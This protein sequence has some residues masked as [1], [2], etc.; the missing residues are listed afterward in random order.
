MLSPTR[1][2]NEYRR[3]RKA[4]RR[5]VSAPVGGWN[6]RDA[7]HAMPPKDA[8]TLDNWFPAVG[9]VN[10]RK[11][12]EQY[13]T[14]VGASDVESLFEYHSGST[15]KFLGAGGG[16][17]YDISSAGAG[18]SLA[19]GF[20]SN[21]WQ[22]TMFNT[23]LHLVNGS[24]DP[25]AYDGS[26]ISS[27]AWSGTGLTISTLNGVTVYRERLFFWQVASQ[28]FWY[29]GVQSVSGTLTKFPMSMLG[30]LGGNIVAMSPWAYADQGSGSSE[31]LAIVMSSGE[32]VVYAGTDPGVAAN[33]SLVGIWKIGAPI[34]ARGVLKL[35]GDLIILT[36]DDWISLKSVVMKDRADRDLSKISGAAQ[37]AALDY[38]A[39][40]GWGVTHYPKGNFLLVNVPV[41]STRFDQHVLNTT[42]KAWCRFTG[43]NGRCWATYNDALYFGGG[44]GKVFKADTGTNDNSEVISADA[45]QAWSNFGYVDPKRMTMIMPV[46]S[47]PGT[48]TITFGLGFDFKEVQ[49]EQST[50]SVASGPLW[51]IATWDTEQWA[52][53][54]APRTDWYDAAGEGVDVSLRLRYSGKGQT[55]DWFR[56]DYLFVPGAGL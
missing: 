30:R 55:V 40:F 45:R 5:S 24:D 37:E 22:G 48:I 28:D 32:I 27:P 4:Q 33:W 11:G 46:I 6:T 9:S 42:T 18:S 19:S 17:I 41:S 7:L 43:M 52:P 16:A 47:A 13:A 21:R 15:R 12:F 20:T 23:K 51:D 29:G 3:R 2:L 8:V 36:K 10:L 38:A 54:A 39:N 53:E 35:A 1:A 44:S 56:T 14:G 50:S 49:V 34:H 26:T 31:V 25:R